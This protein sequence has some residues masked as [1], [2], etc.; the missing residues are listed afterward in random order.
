MRALPRLVVFDVDG[1]LIDSQH[2]IIASVTAAHRALG[3][4]E[5]QPEAIRRVIGLSLI[6][7]IAIL[8]PGHGEQLHLAVVQSYKDAFFALRAQPGHSEPL[9]PG[10]AEALSRFDAEGWLLGI[11][12]GKSR[13]GLDA[14]IERHG[15]QGRFA[16]MQTADDHPG[17]PH[18]GMVLGAMAE[19]G[20]APEDTVMIGDTT[21]DVIMGKNARV[22]V[23]GVAWGYHPPEE[24]LAA[25]AEVLVEDYADLPAALDVLFGRPQCALLRS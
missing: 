22:H 16:T 19:T 4:A 7:A 15:F 18:P 3:L 5:P 20:M 17:K 14:M 10:A 13:R 25:G 6:E 2:N 8:L 11:A 9:F 24:L 12:T 21:F 1:T 23:A